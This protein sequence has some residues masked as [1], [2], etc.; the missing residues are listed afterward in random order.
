MYC[1]Y[2][3]KQLQLNRNWRETDKKSSRYIC[4]KCDTEKRHTYSLHHSP[5][6]AKRKRQWYLDNREASKNS[7]KKYRRSIKGLFTTYKY[8]AK[9]RE[10]SFKLNKSVF[11]SLISSPC[12]YCGELRGDFNGIDRLDNAK[13]YTEKNCVPCCSE[14]NIMKG[15]SQEYAFIEKIREIFKKQEVMTSAVSLF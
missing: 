15:I 10:I 5:K 2:C 3:N 7:E 11:A 14:C 12:Y 6:E 8:Q 9:K 4:K 13:N 1:I